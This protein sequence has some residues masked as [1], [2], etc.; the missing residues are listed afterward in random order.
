MPRPVPGD[1]DDPEGLAAT[2]AAFCEWLLIRNYSP[3]TVEGYQRA[4]SHL[5]EWLVDR[6]VERPAEVTLPMLE[7]YQR[8]LF[9]YR[10]PNGQPLTF[11]AQSAR[12]VP[13][14]GYFRWLARQRRIAS[15]PAADLE[16]PKLRRHLP[17]AVLTVEQVETV[18]AVPDLDTPRGVRDRAMLEMLY[19]NGIRGSELAG[20]QVNDVDLAHLSAR[21]RA[22][23][24]QTPRTVPV[25]E[26]AAVWC[27]KWLADARD[28]FLVPPDDGWLFLNTRGGRLTGHK[29]GYITRAHFNAA[30]VTTP[31]ACHLLRHTCATLMLEGGA[32]I[33]F[34]QALLGH[35]DLSTT[36]IYTQVAIGALQDVHRAC[37]PGATNAPHRRPALGRL[38]AQAQRLLAALAAEGRDEADELA[39]AD[40]EDEADEP[41]GWDDGDD[42]LAAWLG[43]G[44]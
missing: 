24:G 12:L 21:I 3:H 42:E 23:K 44:D 15:N 26:R 32:D 33:R 9:H 31:G 36:Q 34:I 11:T 19:S 43:D 16:L 7:S 8:M 25:G 17:R 22:G 13:V 38:G 4:L 6:G 41:D 27:E 40:G 18:M 14:R 1:P 5:A 20:L 35:A 30:G 37:H 28:Y 10:Q 2:V 39:D 29:L